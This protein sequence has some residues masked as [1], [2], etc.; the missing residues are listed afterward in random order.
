MVLSGAD[1]AAAVIGPGTGTDPWRW[2]EALATARPGA[3]YRLETIRSS[4]ARARCRELGCA[5]GEIVV[6]TDNRAGLVRLERT[7]GRAVALERSLAWFVQ[8][9]ADRAPAP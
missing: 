4:L 9:G 8:I 6:C 2:T 7:D 1:A 3:R 5:E